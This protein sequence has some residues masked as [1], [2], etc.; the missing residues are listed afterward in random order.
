MEMMLKRGLISL[1]Y[2]CGFCTVGFEFAHAAED[3][4]AAT[5][6]GADSAFLI[7]EC[8]VGKYQKFTVSFSISKNEGTFTVF[9]KDSKVIPLQKTYTPAGGGAFHYDGNK[10]VPDSF[11]G[12]WQL[13]DRQLK[14]AS[15]MVDNGKFVFL[16]SD[17]AGSVLATVP[18]DECPEPV[19]QALAENA[20]AQ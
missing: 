17:K 1:L 14:I 18:R 4:R 11:G 6:E 10:M 20:K 8:N 7:Y 15:A 5:V 2:L 13:Q 16:P 9:S 12:S 19:R 3:S